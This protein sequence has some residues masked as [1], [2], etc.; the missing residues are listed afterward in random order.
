MSEL[1]LGAL[2][3]LWVG[4]LT[5]I[6]P[7]PLATNIA[8]ISF[9]SR[10]IS[11]TRVVF[12]MGLL[13]TLGRMLTYVILAILL[14]T[15]ILSIPQVSHILQKY[16]NKLLGPIL[17]FVGMILLELIHINVSSSGLT[18]K[19]QKRVEAGGIWGAGL[20]GFLFALSFC[21]ISAALFFGSLIPL[22]VK[23]SSSLMLPAL[24][25]IGTGLPVFLFALLIAFGAQSVGKTF[26]KLTQLEWWTRRITG[27][28]FILI[29]IYFCLAHIFA[30][31][32]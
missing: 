2:S 9:I 31:F 32:Q 29:G 15:S 12:L 5:S 11:R 26:N 22:S 10:R 25:G 30:I 16:M 28:I 7:C 8:A 23:C 6:S 17:I 21:P 19:M 3:A 24:Y 1:F 20:L 27:I 4:I 14:V 18:E 13:Y